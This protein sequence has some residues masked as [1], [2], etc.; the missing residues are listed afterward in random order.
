MN[1]KDRPKGNAGRT[2]QEARVWSIAR[3][4]RRNQHLFAQWLYLH[5]RDGELVWNQ[6]RTDK[7][8]TMR[9][10]F[11]D[12]SIFKNGRTLFIEMKAPCG[13]LERDQLCFQ[14]RLERQQFWFFVCYS[15]EEAIEL[16]RQKLYLA[17]I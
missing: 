3:T 15:A 14:Q 1:P 10:G 8:S 11:P 4:E 6:A 12:F 5:E 9:A 7:K 17:H 16:V 13:T 2:A